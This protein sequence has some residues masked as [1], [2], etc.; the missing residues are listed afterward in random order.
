MA[1]TDADAAPDKITPR[2]HQAHLELY[3]MCGTAHTAAA[4]WVHI[5]YQLAHPAATRSVASLKQLQQLTY[6]DFNYSHL[7]L[8]CSFAELMCELVFLRQNRPDALKDNDLEHIT[9][10][11][12]LQHLEISDNSLT[13]AGLKAVGQL[14]QLT[15]LNLADNCS[16]QAGFLQHITWLQQL[17]YIGR[18]FNHLQDSDLHHI[19]QLQ[20]LQHLE[21]Q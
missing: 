1:S 15:Y 14:E 19:A 20:Q 10:L 16:L 8:T 2:G 13:S 11:Q 5:Q 18:C 6:L 9:Q 12:Q 7:E 4:T 21:S 3:C 17:R